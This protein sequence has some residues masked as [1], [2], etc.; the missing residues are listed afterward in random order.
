MNVTTN[1]HI[2][3]VSANLISL[4]AHTH[5][6]LVYRAV[7]VDKLYYHFYHFVV[8]LSC[9]GHDLCALC[10]CT[11]PSDLSDAIA[12]KAGYSV[13]GNKL[14]AC[15]CKCFRM[16]EAVRRQSSCISETGDLHHCGSAAQDT[17]LGRGEV[18][19]FS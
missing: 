19:V 11:H 12:I 2:V 1:C 10:L 18:Q 7:L 8:L 16:K 5:T 13:L 4:F 3:A 14:G 9:S 15:R 6:S 17:Q